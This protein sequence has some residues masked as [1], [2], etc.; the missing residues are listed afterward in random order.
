MSQDKKKIIHDIPLEELLKIASDSDEEVVV[1]KLTEAAKF[2]YEL[3]IKHGDTKIP[4]QIVY[5][6]YKIWKG[7]QNK[8]QAKPLFFKDFSKYFESKRTKDGV[9]Y[10]LNPKPFD[11]TEETYWIIRADIRREKSKRKKHEK[12]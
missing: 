5:H 1:D 9:H 3:G 4:A 12:T 10:L 6:T 7:W 11:L 8:K 2:I